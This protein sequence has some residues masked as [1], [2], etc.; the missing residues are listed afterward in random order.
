[1]ATKYFCDLCDKEV[2]SIYHLKTEVY[3][4]TTE[5]KHR[6]TLSF[7]IH[8]LWYEDDDTYKTEPKTAEICDDCLKKEVKKALFED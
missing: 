6:E 7:R 4:T 2:E 1:M 5:N 8:T 3:H